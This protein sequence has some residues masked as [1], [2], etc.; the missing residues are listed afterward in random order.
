MSARLKFKAVARDDATVLV[1]DGSLREGTDAA[2][3]AALAECKTKEIVFDWSSLTHVNSI[4]LAAMHE[5]ITHRP[6][7]STVR[8]ERVPPHLVDFLSLCPDVAR[9]I[10]VISL[11]VPFGPCRH[12][13]REDLKLFDVAA[14]AKRTADPTIACEKCNATVEPNLD[15]ETYLGFLE[16]AA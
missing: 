1:A 3:S 5:A 14:L 4:G 12:C 9:G 2:I 11:Y 16:D 8:F 10:T 15:L 7:G 13:G 6:A